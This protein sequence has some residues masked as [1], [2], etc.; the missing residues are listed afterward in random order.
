MIKPIHFKYSYNEISRNYLIYILE[1]FF[2]FIFDEYKS[3]SIL[4]K[5][6]YSKIYLGTLKKELEISLPHYA[7]CYFV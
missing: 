4:A 6:K 7:R 2:S 3:K 1:L 5:H